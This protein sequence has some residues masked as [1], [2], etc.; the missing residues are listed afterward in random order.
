MSTLLMTL[1][2][3]LCLPQDPP[4]LPAAA[5]IPVAEFRRLHAE[6]V[7]TQQEAWQRIPWQLELLPAAAAARAA[8]KRIFLWSMNG[9][10][11]G[12]T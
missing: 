9:H 5:P 12:C 2:L 6:L 7:P 11:L 8:G 1:A 3:P 4:P 10:P